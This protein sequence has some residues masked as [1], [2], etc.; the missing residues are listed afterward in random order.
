MADAD[1]VDGVRFM[2]VITRIWDVVFGRT[3]TDRRLIRSTGRTKS[4]HRLEPKPE[5]WN[6]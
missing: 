4:G 5:G 2:M 6:Y 3:G 1:F